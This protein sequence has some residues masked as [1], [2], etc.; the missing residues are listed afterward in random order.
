M[1]GWALDFLSA[2]WPALTFA[3]LTLGA[4]VTYRPV[5]R[6]MHWSRWATLGTQLSLAVVLTL[7]LPPGPGAQT[8]TPG[9]AGVGRCAASLSD[10]HLLA[11][12]LTATTDRGE[13]V[14]NI[15]MFVPLTFF[16]VLMSRRPA[17]VAAAGIGLSAA[18]EVTQSV[19]HLG[20]ECVGYDWVNNAIGAV[21]GVLAG[22]L[23]TR[24]T[25]RRRAGVSGSPPI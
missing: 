10:A 22:M 3:A 20:R 14:G 16:A 4:L 2:P 23:A 6:R 5:A 12:A 24:L 21:L 13:R 18:I 8:G 1:R 25:T 15:L 7:T 11:W 19:M 17:V 9:V